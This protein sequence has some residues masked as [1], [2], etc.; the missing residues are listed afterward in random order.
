MSVIE[1]GNL[2]EFDAKFA[3][4][5]KSDVKM[6]GIN[7]L[8]LLKQ[9]TRGVQ[10]SEIQ[11][12]VSREKRGVGLKSIMLKKGFEGFIQNLFN[13]KNEVY[14]IAWAW[15]LSGQ[16]IQLYPASVHDFGKLLIPMKAGIARSF[17]GEGINLFPARRVTGGLSLRIQL[18]ES[19]QDVRDLGKTIKEVNNIIRTSKLTNLL[20]MLASVALV[21]VATILMIK[22]ASQE[23]ADLV[24]SILKANS[25]DYVDLFEG[26]YPASQKW[27]TTEI[28]YQGYASEIQL[29][30][31]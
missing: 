7:N 30:H 22:E 12:E 1:N 25:D 3:F 26:Y 15:D 29:A 16:P 2:G 8:K 10:E 6:E 13:T 5:G 17:I 21:Q 28:T 27:P 11:F 4:E 31:F 9:A 18:W 19:D 20:S 23:L 24:G 14:F